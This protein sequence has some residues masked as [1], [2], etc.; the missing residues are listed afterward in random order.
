MTIVE[1]YMTCS[2]LKS[3]DDIDI[4]IGVFIILDSKTLKGSQYFMVGKLSQV[5]TFFTKIC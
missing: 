5:E 1:K 2:H 4:L 3:S